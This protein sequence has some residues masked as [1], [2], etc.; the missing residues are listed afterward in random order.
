MRPRNSVERH[1]VE[2]AGCLP[3]LPKEVIEWAK[4]N[5][6]EKVAY[7]KERYRKS[8]VWCQNCGHY[9]PCDGWL[10]MQ[11]HMWECP[12]CH[13]QCEVRNT[14]VHFCPTTTVRCISFFDI[15]D[16]KQCIRTFELT[17]TLSGMG[18][19]PVYA[20]AE[21]YQN[22]ILENGVEKITSRPYSR[23]YNFHKWHPESGYTI[24]THN[25]RNSGYYTYDD[26]YEPSDNYIYP[27]VKVAGYLKE[28]GITA[29]ML[30]KVLKV[31]SHF[32]VCALVK[33]WM[34]EPYYETLW[35][36]GEGAMFRRFAMCDDVKLEDY[37]D[38]IRVAKRHGYEFR[39][40]SMWVDY[41]KEMRELGMDDRSPKYLC[42]EDL[43]KAHARTSE[44]LRRRRD[45]EAW[46]RE[47]EK[48]E[49]YE[50]DYAKKVAPWA[51]IVLE[52]GDIVIYPFPTVR[53][54]YEE[55]EALHHCIY[56][57][58]YYRRDGILLLTARKRDTGARLES[59]E[60]RLSDGAILQSRGLK[61][62]HTEYHK[63]IIKII[64]DN[65]ETLRRKAI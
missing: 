65:K 58:G 21:R 35:K 48:I 10:V 32:N 25:A 46:K 6:F 18:N 62:E 24:Q 27:K 1:L 49:G 38:S 40:A 55:G 17:M 4:Q 5:I 47:I 56:K 16:A 41:V 9:E 36:M 28:K 63:D 14:K 12:Q 53:E 20:A 59:I 60:Y 39:D 37:K 64:N 42:P 30:K 31:K 22:W 61:N 33:K 57:M 44:R 50:E 11:G 34:K 7:Y 19:A 52:S 23:G 43:R 3:P 15:Q 45:A 8:T 29:V 13:T 2:V 54:V 51:G 26:M